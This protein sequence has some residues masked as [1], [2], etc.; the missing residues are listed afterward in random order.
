MYKYD[1]CKVV[2][3]IDGDTFDIEFDLG[4]KIKTIWNTRLNGVDCPESYRPICRGEAKFASEANDFVKKILLDKEI[5]VTSY[6]IGV[7]SRYIVD[8]HYSDGGNF[9]SLADVIKER[10]YTKQDLDCRKCEF[11]DTCETKEKIY[12]KLKLRWKE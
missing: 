7:Y 4:F 5:I 10:C 9:V 6:K 2:R 1:H 12:E 3:V 11:F 8:I